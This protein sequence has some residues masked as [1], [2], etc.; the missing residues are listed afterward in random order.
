MKIT[1]NQ[2]F[3]RNIQ[4]LLF[5]ILGLYWH[6]TMPDL[7]I[8][9]FFS[10]V[11]WGMMFMYDLDKYLFFLAL[12]FTF[13]SLSFT[14]L[15]SDVGSLVFTALAVISPTLIGSMF[16]ERIKV[17]SVND[18][19]DWYYLKG[20]LGR[21]TQKHQLL[22]LNNYFAD[23]K[24][25]SEENLCRLMYGFNINPGMIEKNSALL[26]DNLRL[27]FSA[28]RLVMNEAKR[29]K[30]SLYIK[31]I[32]DTLILE[33]WISKLLH[34]D[35]VEF[36]ATLHDVDSF[37]YTQKHIRRYI[38][39]N[40]ASKRVKNFA[41]KFANDK[42]PKTY[43]IFQYYF[44]CVEREKIYDGFNAD[45][46][47]GDLASLKL[48]SDRLVCMDEKKWNIDNC[49]ALQQS[50][51]EILEKV[52]MPAITYLEDN[53]YSYEDGIEFNDFRLYSE[54]INR[55]FAKYNYLDGI[56]TNLLERF[57]IFLKQFIKARKDSMKGIGTLIKSLKFDELDVDLKDLEI[58]QY[59]KK[60]GKSS[61]LSI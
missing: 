21:L 19:T 43:Y 50:I 58:T 5:G 57:E 37:N 47:K 17:D 20:M 44:T 49:K 18:K 15:I 6:F 26:L 55:L 30:L 33:N 40:F 16:Q 8:L 29:T 28:N 13:F 32:V 61:V 60:R 45:I 52:K 3:I 31:S 25:I 9:L 14:P 56:R 35:C 23:S 34:N 39:K 11:L 2:K 12:G 22:A 24:I 59:L 4:L 46:N 7:P 54:S 36:I 42:N 10:L 48:I 51:I 41:E 27:S 53:K 1:I 38:I